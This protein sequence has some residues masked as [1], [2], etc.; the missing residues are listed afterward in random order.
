[1]DRYAKG[2]REFAFDAFLGPYNLSGWRMWRD[3]T[4][5]IT[6]ECIK[7]HGKGIP[8]EIFRVVEVWDGGVS[9]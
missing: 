4:D 5:H 8:V 3:L 6:P 1:M 9:E 7:K 2:V